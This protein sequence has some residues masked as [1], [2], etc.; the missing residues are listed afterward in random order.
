MKFD[1][2]IN[3]YRSE[4]L[5]RI[6]DC[7]ELLKSRVATQ[8]LNDELITL[9]SRISD[10]IEFDNETLHGRLMKVFETC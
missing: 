6:K 9:E 2:K 5:W 3:D 7:E 8:E 1:K 10:K 4:V